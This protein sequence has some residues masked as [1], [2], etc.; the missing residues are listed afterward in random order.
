VERIGCFTTGI[1]EPRQALEQP[2]FVRELVD[3]PEGLE[4]VAATPN[5]GLCPGLGRMK[6][7]TRLDFPTR[8]RALVTPSPCDSDGPSVAIL[9]P[10]G[11]MPVD[12]AEQL[13]AAG[14]AAPEVTAGAGSLEHRF[15]PDTPATTLVEFSVAALNAL[16]GPG[17]TGEWQ[18]TV[19]AKG[20]VPR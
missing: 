20:L 14:V 15:P 4:I 5:L 6:V 16:G 3:A 17:L 13:V 9:T 18:W 11:T 8:W 7:S 10:R 2:V 19:R 12:T 1:D